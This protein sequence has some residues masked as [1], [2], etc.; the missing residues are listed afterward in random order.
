MPACSQLP[1]CKRNFLRTSIPVRFS[2]LRS[3][4]ALSWKTIPLMGLARI[5][6]VPEYPVSL[7]IANVG[8]GS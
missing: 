1:G 6:K 5:S 7:L 2:P 8:L 3:L 4:G